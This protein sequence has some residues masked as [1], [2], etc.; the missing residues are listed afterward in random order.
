[1]KKILI[2]TSEYMPNPSANG[3]ISKYIID[4][5]KNRNFSV[6][7]VSVKRE[8]EDFHEIIDNVNVYRIEP[9]LYARIL[10]KKSKLK[11]PV[12]KKTIFPV[13][14]L[15]RKLKL[16]LLIFNFPNFD[17]IQANKVYKKLKFL[18]K[19]EKY[20]III[21]V[22]KPY[23][24]I[25]A[26]KKFKKKHPEVMC[27]GYYLDLINSMQKPYIMPQKFYN[28]LCYKEDSYTFKLLDLILMAK[29][30]KILYT[31]S[32]YNSVRQKI[33]YVDFPTFITEFNSYKSINSKND[34]RKIILTYAGTLD[35]KYR[36]PEILLN[37]L[38]KASK[39]VG[40]IEFNIYGKNNCKELFDKY[41]S[42][43]Y[44]QI[45]DYGFSSHDTVIKSMYESDI[46]INIS[47][48]IQHAVPSKIFEIFSIGKPIINVIFDK[49]DITTQY[50]KKYP[51]VLNI[52][53]WEQIDKQ[54]KN[55]INF[56]N[57]EKGK[58]YDV[59]KIKEKYIENTPEYVVNIIE[60][61]I[62]K[63]E[64]ENNVNNKILNK[65]V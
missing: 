47:N 41:N 12:L 55:V 6:S 39:I 21:G 27:I 1:M 53:A 22:F 34:K 2:L 54:I 50:F 19:K 4:E 52:K 26:L 31:D 7:C 61:S 16:L 46:L 44:L 42:N 43:I 25:A 60:K 8:N 64:K 38:D 9:S 3:L 59:N 30:G 10:Y 29:G 63:W 51:S 35:I 20:D 48:K 62:E 58:Q 49:N 57:N 14:H 65:I 33:K 18:H 56:I 5:L 40:K 45:N 13:I 28:W 24:N 17:L 37:I 15:L 36:N 11:Y 32:I 23:W